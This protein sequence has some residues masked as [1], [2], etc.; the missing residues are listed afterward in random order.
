LA[1]LRAVAGERHITRTVK[2]I[3]RT[4]DRAVSPVH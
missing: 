1:V 3:T 2:K 4:D